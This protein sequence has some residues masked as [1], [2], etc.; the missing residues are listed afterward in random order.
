M[1]ALGEI[2][3]DRTDP[4]YTWFDQDCLFFKTLL[5]LSRPDK[6]IVLHIRRSSAQHSSDVLLAGFHYVKKAC[7]PNQGIHLH[8]FTGNWTTVED[9]LDDFPNTYFGFTARVT[10]FNWEQREGLRAVPLNRLLL[11]TDSPYMP[12]DRDNRVNIP[13]YIGD[14]AE[15]VAQVRGMEMRELLAVTVTLGQQLYQ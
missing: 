9:W 5:A 14:V 10:S 11:E 1:K 13:A 2:G 6:V 8:C 4:E 15:V 7:P 3:L 12:V